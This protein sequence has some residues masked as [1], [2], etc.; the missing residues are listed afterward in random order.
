LNRFALRRSNAT[1][2][3]DARKAL[4]LH[5]CVEAAMLHRLPVRCSWDTY[6]RRFV[7]GIDEAL[8]RA[9]AAEIAERTV[10]II[11]CLRADADVQLVDDV[12]MVVG[13]LRM[14]VQAVFPHR[15]RT[16]FSGRSDRRQTP[17]T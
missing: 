7:R 17:P 9:F 4:E 12:W 2:A 15:C 6:R 1:L 14:H 3:A 5:G 8:E 11:D 13:T 10:G 16:G